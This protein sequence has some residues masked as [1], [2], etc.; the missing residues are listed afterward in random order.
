M[1]RDSFAPAVSS[2]RVQQII[3]YESTLRHVKMSAY[4]NLTAQHRKKKLQWADSQLTKGASKRR[5]TV[6][7]DEKIF[8]LDGPDELNFY[9]KDTRAG[10]HRF[11]HRQNGSGS[12][13]VWG[14]V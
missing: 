7:S 5:H 10:T 6:F 12:L 3:N 11:T 9:W 4:P 13:L 14:F 1:L 2:R 8:T